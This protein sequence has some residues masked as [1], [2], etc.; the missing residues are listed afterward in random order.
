MPHRPR[1]PQF[2]LTQSGEGIIRLAMPIIETVEQLAEFLEQN[3]EWRRRIYSILVP[4]ELARLPAEF[5]EFRAEVRR[6]FDSVR[7][8]MREGFARV[9]QE[10][11]NVRTEMREGFARVDQEIENVRTE[12]REGFARVDQEIE[13]VRTEMRE[14]FARVDQEIENVRTEMR[15]GF[16]RVDQE[17]ENVRTEM[18]EGFARVDQEIE[19]VRTEMREGFARVDQEIE[20]VRTEM[21]EGF[22]RVDQEIENVRTEMREGFARVDQE[23]ENVRTEMRGGYERLERKIQKNTDDIA[24]LKGISLEQQYRNR[25]RALFGKYIRNLT[26]IDWTDLEEQLEAVAPLTEKEREEL[27]IVDLLARGRRKADGQELVLVIEI[28]WTLAQSDVERAVRRAE[29][30]T[31]RGIAAVAAVAGR[32]IDDETR[33]AAQTA[34]CAVVMDGR[35]EGDQPL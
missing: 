29:I 3:E 31:R 18:R 11:E 2:C 24:E 8:E 16:A 25:A 10:I 20:N 9:D 7:T 33:E 21:R 4:R 12:M 13:N 32:E 5:D 17:I 23:I 30:L 15:E 35:F 19:N 28:S 14:G 22:A 6:E 26:V 1:T 34:G 27:S